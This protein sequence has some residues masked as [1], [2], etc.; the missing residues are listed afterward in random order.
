MSKK[1]LT[2]LLALTM[3]A[4][5]IMQ[6]V[7]AFAQE[8]PEEIFLDEE[9]EP[10]SEL[11]ESSITIITLITTSNIEQLAETA[12]HRMPEIVDDQ[13]RVTF[14]STWEMLDHAEWVDIGSDGKALLAPGTYRIRTTV[15]TIDTEEIVRT[16]APNITFYVDHQGWEKIGEST[17]KEATFA[18]P[19]FEVYEVTPVGPIDPGDPE[20]PIIIVDPPVDPVDP[21]DPI[22]PDKPDDNKGTWIELWGS[23]YYI[24][25]EGEPLTGMQTIGGHKYYFNE[26]GIL[27]RCVFHQEGDKIY[28]FDSE[29]IAVTGWLD[30]WVSTYYFDEEGVMQTGFVDIDGDTYYFDEHGHQM[31]SYWVYEDGKT[32]YIKADGTMAKS[33]DIKRWG[34]KY[35]FGADGA[36]LN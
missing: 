23:I 31:K 19:E 2:K 11:S 13:D 36:L 26:K 3:C 8:E 6:P 1:L 30:R 7:T 20:D 4:G 18:S 24:S 27:Q 25:A 32:Y 9:E 21:I 17:A 12:T 35:S 34:K 33:E 10:V 29:G 15:T 14:Y 22:D 5:L 28:Y 16:F